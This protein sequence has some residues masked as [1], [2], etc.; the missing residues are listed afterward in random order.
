MRTTG[1]QQITSAARPSYKGGK[2]RGQGMSTGIV[3]YVALFGGLA[4]QMGVLALLCHMADLTQ[5]NIFTTIAAYGI[6][7]GVYIVVDVAWVAGIEMRMLNYFNDFYS[8]PRLKLTRPPLIV[9]FFFFAAMAN[10]LVVILPALDAAAGGEPAYWTVALRAFTLGW[11][12]YGNLALVQAWSY[13][14]FPLELVGTLPLSGGALSA[15][16]SIATVAILSS[17]L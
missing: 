13:P 12:S 15:A 7:M 11:Y 9:V 8:F 16:S 3:G 14:G 2:K 6:S 10:T 4:A 17:Q 5:Q 1:Y